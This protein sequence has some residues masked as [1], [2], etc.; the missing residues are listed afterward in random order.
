MRILKTK[1][2]IK[3]V[4]KEYEEHGKSIGFVPTMGALHEGHMSLIYQ[5][6]EENDI[7]V[8]SI[9]VNPTQFNEANDLEKY[10]RQLDQDITFLEAAYCDVLF[11]PEVEEMYPANEES[12]NFEFGKLA[13]VMEGKSRPGHFR[14]VATIVKKLLDIVTP[15]TAYFG[16]KDYQQLLIIRSVCQQYNISTEIIG[17]DIVREEDGLAMS[18][19]NQRLSKKQRE[20]AS[21]IYSVLEYT[22]LTGRRMSVNALKE[23]VSKKINQNSEMNLEYFE[24]SDADDLTPIEE[25]GNGQ[26]AMAFIVVNMGDVRL[27]DNIEL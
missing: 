26:K 7:C 24:L 22:S 9:F 19:R 3:N 25:W 18:S 21:F 17:C 13:E 4:L 27:I 14:G 15:T 12:I 10:P 11:L 8:C 2:E 6:K 23:W 16:K 1:V 20:E 5:A